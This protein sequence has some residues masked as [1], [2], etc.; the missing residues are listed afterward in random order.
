MK[1]LKFLSLVLVL[2]IALQ[3][4]NKDD[5]ET[6]LNPP[7]INNFELGLEDS[8]IGYLGAEL[9]MEAEIVAEAKIDR[10]QVTIH[11]EGEHEKS[12]YDEEEWE[13]DTT[14][15]KFSGLKNT[16]F[17][18]HVDVPVHAEE[19]EYHFHFVVIDM[20]G[21]SKEI[22]R[23]LE[24]MAPSDTEAPTV[25]IS[26]S[27]SNGQVF[28]NGETISISGTITDNLALGGLYVGLVRSNQNLENADVNATNT[29]TLLHTHDF[30]GA[31]E[32]QFSAEIQVGASADNDESPKDLTGDLDGGAAWQNGEYYLLVKSPDAFGGGVAFSEKYFIN[33]E[34]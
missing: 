32:Y 7:V 4:C 21:N 15:T 26:T 14:Y 24:I 22:E 33:I 31:M 18:E 16:E 12:V 28:Q 6:T 20:E 34:L 11:H 19:G 3:A 30:E 17:H 8:G 9:H 2:A 25:T 29:I 10:I 13:V 27:P 1:Q 23:E 5:D